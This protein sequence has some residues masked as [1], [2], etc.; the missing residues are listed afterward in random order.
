MREKPS[1]DF[2]QCISKVGKSTD[3]SLSLRICHALSSRSG[4][5]HYDEYQPPHILWV[6]IL[7]LLCENL[8][9]GACITQIALNSPSLLLI[10]PFHCCGTVGVERSAII[11]VHSASR[12]CPIREKLLSSLSLSLSL[13]QFPL[14][15]VLARSLCVGDLVTSSNDIAHS[16]NCVYRE[17][18]SSLIWC[19]TLRVKR[20]YTSSSPPAGMCRYLKSLR[21]SRKQVQQDLYSFPPLQCRLGTHLDHTCITYGVPK[22][23]SY[24]EICIIRTRLSV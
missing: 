21:L 19:N 5:T 2:V 11:V 1:C 16:F 12:R 13:S 15:P 6:H 9:V 20:R 3:G 18:Y 22:Q 4:V 7:Q 24:K 23:F 17:Q 8:C 14:S 10:I